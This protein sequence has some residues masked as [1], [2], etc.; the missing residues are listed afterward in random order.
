MKRIVSVLGLAG[1]L[2]SCTPAQKEV[3]VASEEKNTVIDK[4]AMHHNR[5]FQ[6]D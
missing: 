6:P 4:S 3:S 1:L 2:F 5:V